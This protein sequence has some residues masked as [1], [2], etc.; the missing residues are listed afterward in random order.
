[1]VLNIVM[2]LKL[3]EILDAIKSATGEHLSRA[4]AVKMLAK[5]DS[6]ENVPLPLTWDS[7]FILMNIC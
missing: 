3:D 1:M 4:F 2:T 5:L 6:F 7:F